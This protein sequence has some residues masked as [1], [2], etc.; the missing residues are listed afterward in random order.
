MP[1]VTSLNPQQRK[2]MEQRQNRNELQKR[3]DLIKERFN[4][5]RGEFGISELLFGR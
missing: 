3:I 1:Q 5:S 2:T 4:P